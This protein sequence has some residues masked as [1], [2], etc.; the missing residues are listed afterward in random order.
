M[1]ALRD[2]IEHWVRQYSPIPEPTP[3]QIRPI[4]AELVRL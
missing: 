4:L 2:T 1:C 3:E